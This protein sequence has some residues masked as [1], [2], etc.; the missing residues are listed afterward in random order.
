MSALSNGTPVRFIS[1][2]EIV[3]LFIF[4]GVREEIMMIND[5]ILS[6]A[7]WKLENFDEEKCDEN[8]M[9]SG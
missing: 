4:I 5:L 9:E 6:E 8:V 1:F 7:S 2:I 3:H